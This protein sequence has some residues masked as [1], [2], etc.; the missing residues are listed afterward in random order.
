VHE[1]HDVG[2]PIAFLIILYNLTKSA[3]MCKIF[4]SDCSYKFVGS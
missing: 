1:G 4:T 3:T 2:H